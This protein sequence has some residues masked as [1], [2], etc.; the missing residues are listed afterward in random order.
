MF[1]SFSVYQEIVKSFIHTT[2]S[3][4]F[5]LAR[6]TF[7]FLF[8]VQGFLYPKIENEPWDTFV[9]QL[10]IDLKSRS[11]Y[12]WSPSTESDKRGIWFEN[13]GMHGAILE[14][15]STN[16]GMRYKIFLKEGHHPIDACILLQQSKTYPLNT[17]SHILFATATDQTTRECHDIVEEFNEFAGPDGKFSFY[18]SEYLSDVKH[19]LKKKYNIVTG[20]ISWMNNKGEEFNCEL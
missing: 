1:H 6:W 17:Q 10:L 14:Y 15:K 12:E 20:E 4:F 9:P 7:R 13:V 19:I 18:Q 16:T 3:V 11:M 5:H 2:K 8:M